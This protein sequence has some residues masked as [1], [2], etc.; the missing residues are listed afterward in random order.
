MILL[1]KSM[2]KFEEESNTEAVVRSCSIKKVLSEISL[3]S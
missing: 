3:N 1:V 2:I